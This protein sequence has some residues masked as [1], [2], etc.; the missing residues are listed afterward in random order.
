MDRE[1]PRDPPQH[2]LR[3]ILP[4]PAGSV[5]KE[6]TVERQKPVRVNACE[7][8]RARKSK[9][10]ANKIRCNLLLLI[11]KQCDNA[12][13]KC[14][15]CITRNTEC[16]PGETESRQFKRRY[17]Q[18]KSKRTAQEELFDMLQN[19][20]ERDAA[21]VFR[22]IRAGANAEAVVQHVQEGSLIME[23]SV[24]PEPSS[25]YHFPYIDQIP[26]RLK[27]S[28][29]FRSQIYEAIEASEQPTRSSQTHPAPQRSIYAKSLLSAKLVD[30]LLENARPSTWTSVSSNDGLMRTLLEGYFLNQYPGQFFFHKD[31]FL[32]DLVSK[33]VRFC[34]PLLVNAILAKACVSEYTPIARTKVD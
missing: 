29:Y 19:M 24:V 18:L 15:A 21:D 22:R 27:E 11:S 4:A 13:P 2:P 1:P 28:T 23:L 14:T 12:R 6:E 34:S 32:E 17:Q 33:G 20:S 25:R 30:P 3:S 31:H 5:R 8:C 10:S 16:R 7:A 9:A 26:S